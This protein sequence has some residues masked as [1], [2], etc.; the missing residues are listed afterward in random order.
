MRE[1]GKYEVNIKAE[2]AFLLGLFSANNII[3]CFVVY[4]ITGKKKN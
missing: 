1:R 3:Y 4:K 2:A